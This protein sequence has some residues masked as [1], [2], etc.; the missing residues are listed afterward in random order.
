[1]LSIPNSVCRK[2]NWTI[3]FQIHS[4][5]LYARSHNTLPATVIKTGFI[6]RRLDLE[7]EVFST[8]KE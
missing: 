6:K 8:E 5:C 4:C 1:M 7:T 2:G 3:A